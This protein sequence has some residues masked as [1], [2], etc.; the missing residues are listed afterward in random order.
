MELRRVDP[1][2]LQKNPGNPRKIQPG[3]MSDA[4][5]KASVST[6]TLVAQGKRVR[7]WPQPRGRTI[8][9]P[10]NHPRPDRRPRTW[11]RLPRHLRPGSSSA[12][13]TLAAILDLPHFT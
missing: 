1:R 4:A 11:S 3:E 13:A 5:M 7:S 12:P 6:L 8:R 10:A 9:D 2:T